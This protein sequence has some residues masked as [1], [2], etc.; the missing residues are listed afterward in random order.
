MP[1]AR[2][3]LSQIPVALAILALT[4][5]AD[6]QPEAKGRPPAEERASPESA[7]N[8]PA[9]RAAP[10]MP[11]PRSYAPPRYPPEARAL[12]V[13]A[14]VVLELDID[15]SGKVTRA[16]VVEPAGNGF[17]EAAIEAARALEFEPARRA[18][19]TPFAARILYRYTFTL[20]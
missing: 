5:A 6:A 9:A 11:R 18:N 19:G 13:E 8:S 1:D 15:K 17:D 2:R 7:A 4:R 10:T 16:A 20:K 14:V 3:S 12:G